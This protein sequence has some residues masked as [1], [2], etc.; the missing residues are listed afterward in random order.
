MRQRH[1]P[2]LA[3]LLLATATTQAFFT[4]RGSSPLLHRAKDLLFRHKTRSAPPA[5]SPFASVVAP[6]PPTVSS[7]ASS[8]YAPPAQAQAPAPASSGLS[9]FDSSKPIDWWRQWYPMAFL[10]DLDPKR[11]TQ[12]ELLGKLF[13]VWADNDKIWHAFEDKCPHRLA[14]LSEGRID[15]RGNL[16]CAYHGWSFSGQGGCI[17]IPQ[18]EAEIKGVAERSGRACAKVVPLR[19]S[20]G[21]VWLWPDNSVEGMEASRAQS[22][23]TVPELHD[24]SFVKGAWV[25]RDLMYGYDTLI[26]NVVDPAHVPF[27]H[28]GVQA[29]RSMAMPLN[30]SLDYVGKEGVFLRLP[31]LANS[32]IEFHAPTRLQYRFDFS[33]MF[34]RIPVMRWVWALEKKLRKLPPGTKPQSALV[35]YTI[36][37]A[38][39]RSRI[40]ALFP[41][42]FFAFN[43]PRWWDHMERNAVLDGDLVFLHG[44]E[45][46]M[47]R[48][49]YKWAENIDRAFYMPTKSDE[50]VRAFRQWIV[51]WGGGG[52]KW[53]DGV[54][55]AL[56]P[57][58]KDRHFLMDRYTQHTSQCSACRGAL[59]NIRVLKGI[60]SV[61]SLVCATAVWSSR[62]AG[63]I[64]KV[65]GT[66]AA[67]AFGAWQMARLEKRMLF[68]DYVHAHK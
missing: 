65:V 28:H 19:V 15:E 59:R 47:R 63:A 46:E 30:V 34:N 64:V 61:L 54:D 32:T 67:F 33:G 17:N 56:P 13:V 50:G 24:P 26:E 55:P 58:S 57:Q 22:P 11:P 1:H 2:L 53:A 7:P 40:V 68:T 60:F 10:D 6:P 62:P 37:V 52:P 21:M 36:P 66:G 23:S 9:P 31:R 42:N 38:P 35:T 16:Q 4:P 48:D 3:L 29:Q 14:P 27:A 45:R 8:S 20:Q 5:A 51:K 39:G 12:L 25:T 18:A 41:R 44:Q 43:K 49:E